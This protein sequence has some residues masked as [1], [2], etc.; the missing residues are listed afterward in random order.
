M[1]KQLWVMMKECRYKDHFNSKN[2]IRNENKKERTLQKKKRKRIFPRVRK[3]KYIKMR[4]LILRVL[5]II[6]GLVTAELY[7][8]P[9]NDFTLKEFSLI[10]CQ[11]CKRNSR[12]RGWR[13]K[14]M[15][16]LKVQSL[17]H[18]PLKMWLSNWIKK[19]GNKLRKEF[20]IVN[21]LKPFTTRATEK[22]WLR[23]R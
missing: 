14:E 1:Y 21:L 13:R 3:I 2:K 20:K 18:I 22:V 12:S 16:Q 10:L 9:L 19:I 7:L 15:L 8:E 17:Y 4:L 5:P 6:S 11:R 23:S